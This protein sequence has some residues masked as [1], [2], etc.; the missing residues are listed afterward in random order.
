MVRNLV[1][2][3]TGFYSGAD[4]V[5]NSIHKYDDDAGGFAGEGV[6]DD[7]VHIVKTHWP[8]R[9]GKPYDCS[10][11]VVLIR[12]PFDS[13][14]S[15][16]KFRATQS[17][18]G[19]DQDDSLTRLTGQLKALWEIYAAYEFEIWK[20]FHTHWLQTVAHTSTVLVLKYEDL[21]GE[22]KEAV[23]YALFRFLNTTD[24]S[25]AAQVDLH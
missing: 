19:T 7:T 23:L 10:R 9:P 14:Y 18:G 24:M 4:F 15:W 8:N 2:K 13:L 22:Q 17:H 25:K 1:Q 6:F 12:N 3:V 21:I 20:K 5:D 16:W 11:A